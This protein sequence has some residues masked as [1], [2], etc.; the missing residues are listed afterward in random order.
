MLTA[1]FGVA[2]LGVT[3]SPAPPFAFSD[4]RLGEDVRTLITAHGSPAVV[5]TD[6]GHVW[7]WERPDK[8]KV[9]LTA[10]DQGR[11]QIIDVVPKA[12]V[13]FAVPS[14]DPK[15]R[16]TLAL[17]QLTLAAA[18]ASALSKSADARGIATFPDSGTQAQFRAYRLSGGTEL[19]LLFDNVRQ[20]LGE[21][22]YGTRDALGRGGLLPAGTYVPQPHYTAPAVLHLGAVDYPATKRQGDAFVKIAVRKDGTVADATIYSSSGS[23]ELDAVAIL[24]AKQD[25]FSP[26]KLDGQPVDS[27]YFHKEEFRTLPPLH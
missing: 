11:V 14:P 26:A 10:D 22:F 18:D 21:V 16:A 19:V 3:G 2:L 9:R 27:V 25:T 12:A 5:T 7:T 13:D 17:D 24:A 4:V 8:P 1:V 20:T 6:V 15:E 23:S